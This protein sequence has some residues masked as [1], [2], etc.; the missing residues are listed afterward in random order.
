[1]LAHNAARWDIEVLFADGKEELGLDQDHLMS[2]TALLRF[3]TLAML[4]YVFLEEEQQGLQASWQ[5]P[6]TIGEVRREIQCRHRR[7]VLAWLHAQFQS[8]VQSD[9]LV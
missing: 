7:R 3:W 8:G 9:S 4:A 6:V 2:T 1:L 5:H